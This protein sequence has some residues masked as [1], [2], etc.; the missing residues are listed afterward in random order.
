[1]RSWGWALCALI[2]RDTRKFAG[3]L[4]IMWGHNENMA[5]CKPGKESSLKSNHAHLWLLSL[6]N[7]EKAKLCCLRHPVYGILLWRPR[8]LL[9][10]VKEKYLQKRKKHGQIWLFSHGFG[11]A[12]IGVVSMN[13]I[14]RWE[15]KQKYCLSCSTC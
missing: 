12:S 5:V 7:C 6:Q 14:A 11:I 3:S 4:S 10:P 2:R 15:G 1:M 8:R 9:R 13:I